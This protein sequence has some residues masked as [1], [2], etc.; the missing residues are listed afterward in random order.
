MKDFDPPPGYNNTMTDRKNNNRK[1][2]VTFQGCGWLQLGLAIIAILV[3]FTNILDP[4]K[5]PNWLWDAFEGWSA[6][7]F[8]IFVPVLVSLAIVI[9]CGIFILLFLILV[10]IWR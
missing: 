3:N 4:S 9:V 2:T 5:M 7:P 8:V 10:G 1:L 6:I